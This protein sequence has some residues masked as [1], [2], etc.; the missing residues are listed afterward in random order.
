MTFDF[1]S[2]ILSKAELKESG[3]MLLDG[4]DCHGVVLWMDYALTETV[5]TSTG[6]KHVS[7]NT[8]VNLC[9]LSIFCLFYFVF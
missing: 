3:E 9:K 8:I 4:E 7:S 1:A 6:L 5:T 2:V